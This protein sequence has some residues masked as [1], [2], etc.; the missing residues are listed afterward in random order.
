MS[1]YNLI[2]IFEGMSDD[3]RSKAQEADRLKDH[4][5]RDTIKNRINPFVI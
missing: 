4:P 5:E 1:K 2:D 3:E